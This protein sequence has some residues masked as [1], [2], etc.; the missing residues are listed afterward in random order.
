MVKKL[1]KYELLYR[2][3]RD[4]CGQPFQ[5]IVE[6]FNDADQSDWRVLDLGCGQGRD[7]LFVARQGHSVLGVDI[8]ETGISQMLEVAREEQLDIDGIVADIVDFEPEEVF[9]VILLD[10]VLHMLSN[11]DDR[12]TVLETVSHHT[13]PGGYVLIA[14]TAKNLRFL[15][16]FFDSKQKRWEKRL[17][18]QG[19][20]FLQS[21]VA[22]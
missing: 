13:K 4:V 3:S 2:K 10:R 5:Q 11:N 14:D 17:E 1:P 18:G 7:A 6:F 19:C 9:D 12:L 16:N 21:K 22:S 8:A 20:L 15:T